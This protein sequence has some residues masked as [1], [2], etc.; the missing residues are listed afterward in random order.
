MLRPREISEN[1]VAT[2]DE[3]G[4]VLRVGFTPMRE[5]VFF[6]HQAPEVDW[7]A[8]VE[9]SAIRVRKMVLMGFFYDNGRADYQSA[10]GCQPAPQG[11]FGATLVNVRSSHYVE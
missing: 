1:L 2:R 10:A 4:S 11:R 7:A 5:G 3:G 6:T 8:A 9:V